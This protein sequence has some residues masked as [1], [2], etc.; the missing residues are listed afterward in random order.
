[1]TL[2]SKIM[3]SARQKPI[4]Q[5]TQG[6]SLDEECA[7]PWDVCLSSR[8]Q[9]SPLIKCWTTWQLASMNP[10]PSHLLSTTNGDWV[11]ISASPQSRLLFFNTSVHTRQSRNGAIK[12]LR[13]NIGRF[14]YSAVVAEWDSMC[15]P[16]C[17]TNRVC[18]QHW[19]GDPISNRFSS[20]TF[21]IFLQGLMKLSSMAG[22]GGLQASIQQDR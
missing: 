8:L 18:E 11:M 19:R 21:S 2:F 14:D 1:M 20:S 4:D 10:I 3:Q 9:F 13:A 5:T 22:S 12:F 7:M 17:T 15:C 6:L 16:L